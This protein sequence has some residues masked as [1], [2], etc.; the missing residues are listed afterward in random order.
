[1]AVEN[2]DPAGRGF[3][4]DLSPSILPHYVYHGREQFLK[5]FRHAVE[6]TSSSTEWFI[7]Q[8]V[9]QKTYTSIFLPAE[10]GPFSR[11]ASYDTELE[12]LLVKMPLSRP[13]GIASETLNLILYKALMPMGMDRSLGAIGSATHHA[14]MGGKEADKAWIPSRTPRG[15]SQDWPSAVLEVA[16]SESKAKLQSDIRYWLHASD[17]EVKVVLTLAI[18]P[19]SPSITIENWG[20]NNQRHLGQ[21][22]QTIQISKTG[23]N[24]TIT[25]APLIIEFERLFLRTPVEPRERNILID[26]GE[27]EY[28][29]QQIWSMQQF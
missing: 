2:A 3:L 12:R 25:G 1:M 5:D 20:M 9:D 27:L 21:L 6:T 19:H 7:V 23:N 22:R 15:R 17:G 13:H 18:N 14:A 4:G 11:G 28:L 16:Y 24:L 29:A 8:G 10:H 26:K